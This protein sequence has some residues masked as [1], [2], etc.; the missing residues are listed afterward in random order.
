MAITHSTPIKLREQDR[1]TFVAQSVSFTSQAGDQNS[2]RAVPDG[3]AW[4][5]QTL[6]ALNG[7]ASARNL[8]FKL[9]DPDGITYAVLLPNGATPVQVAAGGE[10]AWDGDVIV[11]AGWTVRA[12]FLAMGGGSTCNWQYTAIEVNG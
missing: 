4:R 6:R 9:V 7:E 11:P 2:S 1:G 3:K 5:L 12:Y 10:L 8:S